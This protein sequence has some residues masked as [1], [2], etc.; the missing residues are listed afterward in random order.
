MNGRVF[1]WAQIRPG[2]IPPPGFKPGQRVGVRW[3]GSDA[4]GRDRYVISSGQE[5]TGYSPVLCARALED[6]STDGLLLIVNH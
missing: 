2:A 6:F 1:K 4:L 3:A 5:F